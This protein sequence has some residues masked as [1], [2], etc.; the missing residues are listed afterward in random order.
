MAILVYFDKLS[1]DGSRVRYAFGGSPGELDRLLTVDKETRE[2]E[3]D[4]HRPDFAFRAT[5]RRIARLHR[6]SGTW[7]DRG[8]IAS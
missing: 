7:P 4:D 5:V 8:M 3:A 2:A 6:T 1:E